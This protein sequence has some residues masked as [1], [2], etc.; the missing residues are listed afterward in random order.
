MSN[1][2]ARLLMPNPAADQHLDV[3]VS[4]EPPYC[5]VDWQGRSRRFDAKRP[6]DLLREIRA[7]AAAVVFP[8]EGVAS[9]EPQ[10]CLDDVEMTRLRVD[11][12][13]HWLGYF[14][15]GR[16]EPRLGAAELDH[17][18][19]WAIVLRHA[20]GRF[21]GDSPLA[22]ACAARLLARTVPEIESWRRVEDARAELM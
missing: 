21:G 10:P 17:P 12:A 1:W 8:G 20:A 2:I 11:V 14:R 18:Q 15:S 5:R 7:L 6:D 9:A 19:T 4:A 22:T 13:L 3:R 16:A